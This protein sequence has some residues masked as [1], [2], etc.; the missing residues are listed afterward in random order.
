[1]QFLSE[2]LIFVQKYLLLG[3]SVCVNTL[4]GA[5]RANIVAFLLVTSACSIAVK[6]YTLPAP[7]FPSVF[8]TQKFP[9]LHFR[10]LSSDYQTILQ[11]ATF[12][13]ID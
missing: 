10:M 2:S 11:D 7:A 12:T 13:V 8:D 6:A 5:M 3:F 1:M 4:P 9:E